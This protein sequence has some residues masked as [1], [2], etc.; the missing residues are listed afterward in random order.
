MSLSWR[1]TT[2]FDDRSQRAIASSASGTGATV[3]AGSRSLEEPVLFARGE[4]Q[5]MLNL[6]GTPTRQDQGL[7][8]AIEFNKSYPLYCVSPAK[9]KKFNYIEFLDAGNN[10]IIAS[11]GSDYMMEQGIDANGTFA[12]G[13]DFDAV[14]TGESSEVSTVRSKTLICYIPKN[15]TPSINEGGVKL[16]SNLSTDP[17]EVE[18]NSTGITGEFN[19]IVT[20][21]DNDYYQ[22]SITL[23]EADEDQSIEANG[24]KYLDAELSARYTRQMGTDVYLILEQRGSG[25]FLQGSIT[26]NILRKDSDEGSTTYYLSMSYEVM[27][28]NG[29]YQNGSGSPVT[30]TIEKGVKDGFQRSLNAETKFATNDYFRAFY[31]PRLSGTTNMYQYEVEGSSEEGEEPT[32]WSFILDGVTRQYTEEEGPLADTDVSGGYAFFH[33]TNTYQP[34]LFFDA[35]GSS[36]AVT[37]LKDIR[38]NYHQYSRVLVP[39]YTDDPTSVTQALEAIDS[40]PADRGF[41]AYWGEFEMNNPYSTEFSTLQGV[42]MGSIAVRHSDAISLSYG[43]LAVAWIDENGVGGQLDSSR[44]VRGLADPT[45]E[46]LKTLDENRIN[47]VIYE[48]TYGPMILSRRTTYSDYS[49]YSFNDYSGIIDYCVKNIIKNALPYQIV[50][51][52]DA[53]H[54]AIVRNRIDSI[55]KPLTVAPYNVLRAYAIKCDSENNTDEVMARE[56]FLVEVAIQVQAKS[57]T[58]KLVF[59]NTAQTTT[60]EE[61]LA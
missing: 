26:K 54:R 55:L 5:R 16:Y 59:I 30:F 8:E 25:N 51:M 36:L 46:E 56:E 20:D 13:V 28:Y 11:K 60:V 31:N 49:D 48:D 23:T 22:I 39:L 6:L 17:I 41:S 35:T 2:T 12:C 40:I 3:V 24:V 9:V 15:I 47:P 52:N 14:S 42:P 61:A 45:E 4:T 7:L 43:G 37:E 58:I 29:T 33:K 10:T 38:D 21:S 19:G 53:T 1:I 34:D 27:G 32:L 57:R 50:K 44:F 18:I